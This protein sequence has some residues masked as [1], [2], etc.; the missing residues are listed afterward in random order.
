MRSAWIIQVGLKSDDKCLTKDRSHVEMEAESGIVQPEAKE[1][2]GP[3]KAERNI[4]GFS[5]RAVR[6]SSTLLTFDF[7]L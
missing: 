7:R 2:P 1:C 6:R 4:E 5:S 3:P